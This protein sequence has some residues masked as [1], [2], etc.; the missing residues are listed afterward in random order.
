MKE[1]RPALE[2]L[3]CLNAQ[4]KTYGQ[5]GQANLRVRKTYGA[6]RIRYLRCGCCGAEF[7]ERKGT[8]LF[9]CKIGEAQAVSVIEHL[10]RA[11][12]LNA[13]AALVGVSKDAVRRLLRVSGQV[14]YQ[15]H[16]RLVRDLHPMAL[17]FDEKWSYVAKKQ[18][19]LTDLDDPNERGDYW[20]ANSLDP[21]SKLLVSLVP[22]RRTTTTL[23]QVV[24]DAAARLACDA[25]LPALFTDGEPTYPEAIVA[26]FG[27]AYP[28]PR[29]HRR[30]R[31]PAPVVRIPQGLVYAQIVKHRRGGRV[32]R[33]EIRPR[34]GKGR[35]AQVVAHLG[36]TKAN[37]SAIERFNLTNRMR[38]ARKGRKTL[39]FSRRSDRHDAL[40][41]IGALRYNFHHPH[42]SLR[43]RTDEGRWQ[44]TT[45]AMAAGIA[46]H[47]YSSLELMRLCPVG[48][49]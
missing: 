45:P 25:R 17:Q 19:H 2:N 12:G 42:R 33:V 28:V 23:H 47:R 36:W 44:P 32:Q 16:D 30:G 10:D 8:A 35:L 29:R 7:S 5:R 20:D 43:Q 41:W 24:A 1:P 39:R 37:T 11:C 21:Q 14:S 38:N 6:D 15:L 49:G 26:T 46:E 31:Q 40:S 48:L 9:N 4:C 34:F 27:R 3:C 22:G 13:T 18:R